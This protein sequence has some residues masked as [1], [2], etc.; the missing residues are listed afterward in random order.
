MKKTITV[1]HTNTDLNEINPNRTEN[2][3]LSWGLQ[4]QH[5]DSSL[6]LSSG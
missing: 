5:S 1:G 2:D 6:L 3:V 4:P